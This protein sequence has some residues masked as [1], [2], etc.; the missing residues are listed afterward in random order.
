MMDYSSWISPGLFGAGFQD[1]TALSHEVAET[2]SDPFVGFDNVHNITLW[3]LSGDQCQDL[4]EVGRRDRESSRQ[5]HDP[6]Q[7]Y[8][9]ADS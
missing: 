5:H 8:S 3:W 4:L 1:V 7:E 6:C 9:R 2:F